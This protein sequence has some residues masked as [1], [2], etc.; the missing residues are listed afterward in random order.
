[1][2]KMDVH[3]TESGGSWWR[4]VADKRNRG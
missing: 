3:E 1:M 2:T 4:V